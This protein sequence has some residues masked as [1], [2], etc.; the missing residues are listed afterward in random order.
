MQIA[1]G[2][3]GDY[4]VRAVLD[5]AQHYGH[6]R[7]KAREIAKAMRIPLNLWGVKTSIAVI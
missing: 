1:L 5:L 4:A 6:G 3:K 2:H 7:R